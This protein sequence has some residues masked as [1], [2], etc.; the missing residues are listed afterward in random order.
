MHNLQQTVQ[1]T[2]R[3]VT[4]GVSEVPLETEKARIKLV[5]IK[6]ISDLITM[7]SGDSSR[8]VK[9]SLELAQAEIKRAIE[10]Q[11]GLAK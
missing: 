4:V 9:F 6:I 7:A 10:I 3:S 1:D 5:E 8:Q 2:S 11:K